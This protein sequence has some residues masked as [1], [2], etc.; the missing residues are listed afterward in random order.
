[1]QVE[2]RSQQ[3]IL[4]TVHYFAC[5]DAETFCKPVTQQYEILLTQDRDG[6]N[7]RQGARRPAAAPGGVRGS[8]AAPADTARLEQMMSRFPLHRALDRDNDGTIS[9]D[10]LA[11]A[12]ES[13]R[14]LDR[15]RDGRISGNEL[16]PM[17]PSGR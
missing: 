6:G 16:R 14:Q 13:L 7:R 1:L 11:A 2:G 10:E 8:A 5:D 15:N 4:L 12:T 9:A 3:P 17:V